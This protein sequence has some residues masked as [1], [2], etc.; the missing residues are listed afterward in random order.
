VKSS[1]V[2]NHVNVNLV[3]DISETALSPSSGVDVMVVLACNTYIKRNEP[4]HR[5]N[6]KD[7]MELAR[8]TGYMDYLVE[9]NDIQLHPN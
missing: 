4:Q 1:W 9:A 7:T 2:T 5:M 8:M 6:Y 3:P